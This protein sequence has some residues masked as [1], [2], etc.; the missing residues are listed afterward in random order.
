[1]RHNTRVFV[2]SS[3]E[4]EKGGTWIT[5]G[6]DAAPAL[7]AL[8]VLEK[9]EQLNIT[10]LNLFPSK[11]FG[12]KVTQILYDA[13]VPYD[14]MNYSGRVIN[15]LVHKGE[16]D[17]FGKKSKDQ[18]AE[19]IKEISKFAKVEKFVDVALLS[20]IGNRMDECPEHIA[21]ILAN[22]Y[23]HSIRILQMG[24]CPNSLSL[25]VHSGSK[26]EGLKVLYSFLDPV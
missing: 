12:H 15:V 6:N 9:L 5:K 2:G 21:K 20:V 4:P 10:D 11:D 24:G 22:F 26:M 25:L 13:K 16:V 7:R 17:R 1:M 3:L 19:A 23:T 8:A 14:F 18:Y